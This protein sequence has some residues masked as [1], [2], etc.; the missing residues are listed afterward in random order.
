VRGDGHYGTPEVMDLLEDQ[1]CGFILGLP[2][3]ARLSKI[4]QPWCEDAAVRRVQSR[5]DKLR[6]FFQT[7][8]SVSWYISSEWTASHISYR[9]RNELARASFRR[10]NR[11]NSVANLTLG[12]HHVLQIRGARH[13]PS[14][15][16]TQMF[17]IHSSSSEV[18]G[19]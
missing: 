17:I 6:R 2:G 8:S 13:L 5:K 3:N 19:L 12:I 7:G 11:R 16:Q 18:F 14:G 1:G 10:S 15:K 4:G 9:L